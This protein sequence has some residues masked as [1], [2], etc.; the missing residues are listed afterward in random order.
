MGKYQ[1]RDMSMLKKKYKKR[2]RNVSFLMG[3][4]GRQQDPFEFHQLFMEEDTNQYGFCCFV[5]ALIKLSDANC[6]SKQ[7]C[8]TMD[9]IN[10]HKHPMILDMI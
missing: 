10:L 7:Y 1:N 9:N 2:D 5:E 4:C 8:F 6:P 3:L